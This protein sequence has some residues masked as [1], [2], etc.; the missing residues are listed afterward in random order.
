M[1]FR[2]L[3]CWPQ[4]EVHSWQF[5][6]KPVGDNKVAVLLMNHA[7]C[8]TWAEGF[9]GTAS[10]GQNGAAPVCTDAFAQCHSWLT[11][12]AVPNSFLCRQRSPIH[13]V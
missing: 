12:G 7:T 6:Y 9:A 11:L 1:A 3:G 10:F 2:P 5:F 8:P 4:H 13:K